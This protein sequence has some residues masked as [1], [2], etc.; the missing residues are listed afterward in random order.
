M[1]FGAGQSLGALAGSA[2]LGTLLTIR[3][4]VHTGQIVEHLTLADPQ[5]VARLKQYAG[6]YAG[7]VTDPVLRQAQSVAL[8]GQVVTR[9]ATALAYGDVFRVIAALS[10]LV[11]FYLLAV[12]LRED[13]RERRVAAL[14][15]K[16][17]A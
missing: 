9:E 16:E 17:A 14:T 3:Q 5:V 2:F 15:P 1:I 11:F 13:A 6:A 7:S 12:R 10:L 4:R 8:L